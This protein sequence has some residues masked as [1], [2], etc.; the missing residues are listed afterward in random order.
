MASTEANNVDLTYAD[1]LWKAADTLRGQIDAAEYKHVVLGLLFLKYISDSFDSRRDDL[2][3]ELTNDGIQGEQLERL[4][5]SRDEYTAERVFWVPPEARW[6]SLQDQATRPDIATLID[7]AILAVERDNENLKGKLPRDYARRGI[8]PVKMKGLIDLFAGIGFKGNR[9]LARDMLGRVY[10]YFLSKFAAAEGKLG[11]EF[12]TPRSVVRVLVEMLEPYEGRIY[13]PACGSGGMFVQSEK[14][15]EAHGGQRTDVSI[16]GQESNP[17]T[18]RLAHMNLA[19]HGI[20]AKLGDMPADTFL[21]DQHPDLKADFVLANPPFNVSDW[22]GKL[23]RSDRRWAYGDPPVGNAN[24]AWIQHFIHHLAYPNGK[25]GG[26]AGFVMANGS[27]S[28]NT[29]GEG[30][31]RRKIIE[32]DLVDCIVALPAQLFF[33]TGIPVCLWFLTRDKTGRNIRRGTPN[34][35]GGRAGETLFID[36]R[37]LGTMQTRVLRV[38]TGTEESECVSGTSDPLPTSDV[39]RIIYAFRRWRGEPAPE[40]WTESEHGPWAFAPT[41]GFAKAATIDEI[42]THGH[43]LTPGRYVGA[44]EQIDDS[45]PFAEKYPRLVGELEELFV[46][47]DR[48]TALVRDLLAGVADD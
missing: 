14:F 30:D 33:T 43:V 47:G 42:A 8:E 36:A 27:L 9:D 11:G 2:R 18:W 22:S 15:V 6:S 12:F 3:A 4:L 37:K 34:R 5:E 7:D 41:P 40:W 45:E 19:I 17:T 44:K 20:E 29:G 39:G 28:S 1:T 13:D 35:P 31:I 32:A 26:A 24:Y 46:E 21:R 25:G 10:E 48:L 16:F 23:L 38:L